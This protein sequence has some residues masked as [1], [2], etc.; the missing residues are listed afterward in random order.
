MKAI[1]ISL[2]LA[3]G[4]FVLSCG[5]GSKVST[6]KTAENQPFQTT[7]STR[8]LGDFRA[9]SA[10]KHIER[11]VAFGPRVPGTEGHKACREYILETLREYAADSIITQDVEAEAFNGDKLPITNIMAQFNPE[12]D[13]RILLVAH[14]DTRP[15]ADNEATDSLRNEPIPGANDGASGVG[16]LLEIA[17]NFQLRD[18]EIG[19]DILFVDAEDYGK[20][21]TFEEETETWALGTQYFVE[22]MPYTHKNRPIYGILLDMV[23]GRDAR[24]HQEMYSLRNAR[25]VTNKV[26]EEASNLGLENTFIKS[27]GGAVTDDHIFL[28]RAGIPTTDIIETINVQ[29]SNFPPTW[30]THS[31]DI[32]NIDRKSLEAVGRTVLNVVYKEKDI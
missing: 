12:N 13:R 18:P 3:L 8:L 20:T 26:W 9:D 21:S 30:H 7:F 32:S 24:F 25:A 11:Q 29:T 23:G 19:V 4:I 10:F 2:T 17:R 31:D 15:W 14:W 27:P 1:S 22:H 16:V 6:E 28:N 5:C